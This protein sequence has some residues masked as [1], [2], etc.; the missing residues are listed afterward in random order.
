MDETHGAEREETRESCRETRR[1]R[2]SG[3]GFT[4]SETTAG[5]AANT[6]NGELETAG[7]SGSAHTQET[8]TGKLSGGLETGATA[9]IRRQTKTN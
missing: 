9:A 1:N 4:T 6:G 2:N 8:T 5:R 7:E 3:N